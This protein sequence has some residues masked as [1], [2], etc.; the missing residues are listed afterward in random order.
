MS[1]G[2]TGTLEELESVDWGGLHHAYGLATDVPGQIRALLSADATQRHRAYYEL[3]GNVYHQGTRWQASCHV[4]PFLAA[5]VDDPATPARADVVRLLRALALGDRDDN[6]LPFNPDQAF[7][8]AEAVTDADLAAALDWLYGG[9]AENGD[10]PEDAFD[11]VALSWD[12]D[13]YLAAAAIRDRFAAWAGD[14]DQMVAARA[15]ELLAWFPATGL[16]VSALLAI[17]ETEGSEIARASANLALGYLALADPEINER[18]TSQLIAEAYGV[19]LTA[20]VALAARLGE[21]MPAP[22][23]DILIQAREHADEIS[24]SRFPVPWDRSLSGLASVALQRVGLS[25]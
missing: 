24:A 6:D 23:L 3:Y 17:P 20:A 22:G 25:P 19:R 21:Q 4:I 1:V 14:P 15:A 7:A 16:A 12:R 11:A 5:F 10:E 13:A 9:A 2:R 8:P 18:L